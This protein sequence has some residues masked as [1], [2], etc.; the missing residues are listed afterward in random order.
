LVR[1]FLTI[2]SSFAPQNTLFSDF[3]SKKNNFL[4]G[5]CFF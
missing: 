4:S 2:P 5:T 1:N 3:A